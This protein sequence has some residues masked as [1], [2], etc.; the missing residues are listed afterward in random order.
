MTIELLTIENFTKLTHQQM[1]DMAA[2]KVAQNRKPSMRDGTCCYA[3]LGCAASVFLKEDKR[4]EADLAGDWGSVVAAG[5][6]PPHLKTF[7][8]KLQQAHDTAAEK[9][10]ELFL[11]Y[12]KDF[13]LDIAEEYSLNPSKV[14][15]V[16]VGA[17]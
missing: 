4:A 17:Y 10:P 6:A 13:M 14:K 2:E 15:V 9:A 8:L 3:G 7:I 11:T 5:Y 1:F 12:W 16:V